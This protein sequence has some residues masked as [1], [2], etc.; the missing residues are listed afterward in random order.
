MNASFFVARNFTNNN[1]AAQ[2]HRSLVGCRTT[3]VK[4]RGNQWSGV[5]ARLLRPQPRKRGKGKG[6]TAKCGTGKSKRKL[7]KAACGNT[8]TWDWNELM[9]PAKVIYFGVSVLLGLF[10]EI[11]FIKVWL[12]EAVRIEDILMWLQRMRCW[13]QQWIT[14]ILVNCARPTVTY[15]TVALTPLYLRH[16]QRFQKM[17]SR[18]RFSIPAFSIDPMSQLYGFAGWLMTWR[19]WIAENLISVTDGVNHC[20]MTRRLKPGRLR[21][22]V[23]RI[24]AGAYWPDDSGIEVLRCRLAVTALSLSA[25]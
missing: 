16:V 1:H 19:Q 5:V 12:N 15:L 13:M 25:I 6:R 18:S 11:C 9:R 14:T 21:R 24:V 2:F 17:L 3:P 7:Y 20:N 23:G 22:S 10:T 8:E 4:S